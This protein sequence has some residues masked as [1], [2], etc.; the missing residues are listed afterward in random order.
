[1]SVDDLGS[2]PC[3]GCGTDQICDS[4]S[5]SCVTCLGDG[6]CGDD[7][8]LVDDADSANNE[9]V[10][11]AD[12]EDCS[13]AL[14]VCDE[15]S[16]ECVGCVMDSDCTEA[17]ASAC[18]TDTNMC[19]GC[20]SDSQCAR[21]PD[22]P[23][24]DEEGGSCVECTADD[25]TECGS[26]VCDVRAGTCTDIGERSAGLCVE[27]V[28]DRQCGVGRVCAPREFDGTD[29]PAVCLWRRDSME[30]GGPDGLC[31]NTRP[32]SEGRETTTVS[33]ASVTV[34]DLR[35]TTCE[36]FVDALS[37]FCS[38]DSDCGVAGLD[39]GLCRANPDLG[40]VCHLPCGGSFDCNGGLVCNTA[41]TSYCVTD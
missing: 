39:D 20:S 24:C 37:E 3:G 28:S 6:D 13:G 35:V 32:Y 21:F 41:S 12:S 36:A 19:E 27:C 34:C 4:D 11:C 2:D 5:G 10:G 40:M 25:E 9:C 23:A 14:G 15:E 29:L 26:N 18:N 31:G 8:C 33:G 22:T 7:V 17:D 30:A 16:N 1:M 38:D